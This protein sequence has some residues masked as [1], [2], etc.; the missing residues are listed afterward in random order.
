MQVS[1]DASTT[2][3][4]VVD[5]ML[6]NAVLVGRIAMTEHHWAKAEH[7]VFRM[8]RLDYLATDIL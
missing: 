5:G 3:G 2:I 1:Y 8:V 6:L 7:S 4:S